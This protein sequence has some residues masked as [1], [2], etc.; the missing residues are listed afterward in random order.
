[1]TGVAD[2]ALDARLRQVLQRTWGF[3]ELKP[4]QLEAM[5]AVAGGRDSLVVLPTGGGKSLCYQAPAL[6]APGLALVVSPLIS[7][8]KDQVDGLVASG[9]AA[10][11]LHSGLELETRR[12]VVR[13]LRSGELALLYVAPERLVGE[14]GVEFQELLA[15]RGVAFFAI[16]EAH[17]ISQWGHDFRPEYRGLAALRDRFPGASFHAFTATA[18]PRVRRDIVEQLG[19]TD[20]AVLIGDFD[21]PNLVYRARHRGDLGPALRE[22][23]ERHRGEAGI[24]YCITRR[25]VDALAAR[26]AQQGWSALP[27]HA[28][29]GDEER[30]R[31]QDAFLEERAGVVVA[32]VAFGMGIDRPD[33][34]FVIHAASPR[35]LEHYQQEAGRAGRDGLP[36]ECLLLYSAADF[37]AWRRLLERD[38]TLDERASRLLSDMWAFAAATRCRHR[39]LVEYFG[40]SLSATSCGACDWC[41]GELESVEEPVVL[42]QKI[43]SGVLRL[44]ESF[45]TR[46]LLDMLRG[47]ATDRV[48]ERGHDQLS[49]FG[50]LAEVP[51]AELRGYVEQLLDAGLLEAA[52]ERYP[53]LRAT[54]AGRQLLKGETTCALYRQHVPQRAP[55]AQ[56]TIADSWDGVDAELFETLRALR[57]ELAAERGVPP[58]VILHDRSLRDLARRRPAT[59]DELLAVHGIGQAKADAYGAALLAAVGKRV[60]GE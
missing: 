52:G 23:L 30:H 35:S 42:A 44:K 5:R 1:M 37:A 47:Q 26:L 33:V 18:T 48:R 22:A 15:E 54:A 55:A 41:L 19:L 40:Q 53:V 24:V 36:A 49:T 56:K 6:L 9:V 4:L 11:C 3:G 28:G 34:R 32:T 12:A 21:R 13:R 16:D 31:N 60:V 50:I 10:A 45:G 38:G 57:R 58:Y 20:P 8:M 51:P 7:L 17:C 46:Q 14:G 2:P 25:D 27:Y 39:A 59:R 29:L 43:L